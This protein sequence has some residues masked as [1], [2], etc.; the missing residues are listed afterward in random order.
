MRSPRP[1]VTIAIITAGSI[2]GLAVGLALTSCKPSLQDQQLTFYA[3]VQS[4]CVAQARVV[5]EKDFDA[6]LA[7]GVACL[8][9]V[10]HVFCG[11]SGVW[12]DSGA[13]PDGDIK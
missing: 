7:Q 6:G 8:Q 2:L 1:V 11:P 4:A 9:Y 12:Q 10:Q 3:G 13:C 5:Q